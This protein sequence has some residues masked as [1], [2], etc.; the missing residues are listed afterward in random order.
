MK[1][2]NGNVYEGEWKGGKKDGKGTMKMANRAVYEGEWKGSNKDGKGKWKS[3]D[4]VV[5]EGEFKDDRQNG[6]GTL[7]ESNGDLFKVIYNQ[8]NLVSRKRCVSS[9]DITAIY[10]AL[11]SRPPH[12][13]VAVCGVVPFYEYDT[14]CQLCSNEFLTDMY[15][16]NEDDKKRLPVLGS[17]NHVYCLGCVF[18]WHRKAP[19]VGGRLQESINCMNCSEPAAFCPSKPRF[20]RFLIDLLSR[21]I[22]VSID[23]GLVH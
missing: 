8:S 5:Y 10:G 4:G 2:A 7:R 16:E 13:N 22:P 20:H 1:W 23:R 18:E 14:E 12:T 21:N 11:S 15:P 6:E 3:A 19:K 17:C 9:G